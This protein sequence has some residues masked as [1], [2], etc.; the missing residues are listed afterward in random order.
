MLKELLY[1]PL[2]LKACLNIVPYPAIL[3]AIYAADAPNLNW[4]SLSFKSIDW[5]S[6]IVGEL[7][8]SAGVYSITSKLSV[9][10]KIWELIWFDVV[11]APTLNVFRL[12]APVLWY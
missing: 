8:S 4:R 12:F 10:P 3:F 9:A 1:F 5:G 7:F 2:A 11:L 6:V